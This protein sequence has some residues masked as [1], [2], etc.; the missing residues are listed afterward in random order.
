MATTTY[1]SA[2]TKL[3]CYEKF[4]G[5]IESIDTSILNTF[6][7]LFENEERKKS[8]KL[9]RALDSCLDN[10]NRE[11]KIIVVKFER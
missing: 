3:E 2:E 10:T 4:Q 7:D 8:Q 11:N 1:V 5:K 9:S 6:A